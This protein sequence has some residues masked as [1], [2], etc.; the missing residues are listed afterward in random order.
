M[1]SQRTSL[2]IYNGE[3]TVFGSINRNAL[4]GL[5]IIIPPHKIIDKFDE[6][7]VGIDSAIKSH[8]LENE[9]LSIL[10]DTLLPKLMSGEIE[11]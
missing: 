11:V 7:V 1:L 8:F 5:K 4:E 2:D 9:R 3:G 6:I 10:R